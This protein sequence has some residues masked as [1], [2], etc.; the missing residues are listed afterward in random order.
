M[1]IAI[2]NF[3]LDNNYGGNLQ[4]FAL[5]RVLQN[6]GHNP[7]H[8]F[9]KL[10][11]P[12]V[13]FI[14]IL[15]R[16]FFSLLHFRRP[17]NLN[18]EKKEKEKYENELKTILPFYNKYIPH[19]DTIDSPQKLFSYQDFDA[20]LVGSDQVW[21]RSMSNKFPFES[22]F[23]DWVHNTES[24]K[25]AYGISFGIDHHEIPNAELHNLSCLYKKFKA[26]SVRETSAIDI[27]TSLNWTNPKAEL[28]L[29][30]TLLID[31][32]DYL[33]IIDD[34][35]T[36]QSNGEL[37][38]YILDSSE[39]SKIAIEK[40]ASEKH[41]TPFFQSI[42]PKATCSIEQWLKSFVDAQYVVTDSFHGCIFSIIFNKPFMLI[43]NERRGMAR[44]ESL[45]KILG[46]N[47]SQQD[48]DWES[49]NSK[50]DELK[51]V[52]ISFIK[53]ALISAA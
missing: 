20:F 13:T 48:F 39:S 33:K 22:M 36:V 43:K 15:Q 14:E 30:P 50:L 23:F 28:V 44:F 45:F 25:I 52:S 41:L 40:K 4:R 24:L 31:K 32:R 11:F 3:P 37:F 27:L 53:R 46:I 12:K 35:S 8:L 16:F 1:K 2:L 21:R 9:T 34:A 29:D 7:T 49:I 6:L 17:I 51:K 5:I 38:C 18:V 47:E 26:V 42:T 10:Y 19:T